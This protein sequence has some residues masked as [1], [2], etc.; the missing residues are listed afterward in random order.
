MGLLKFN[1]AGWNNVSS[2]LSGLSSTERDR[3]DMTALL[4]RMIARGAR[5][6]AVPIEGRWGEVDNASDLALYRHDLEHGLI[7]APSIAQ[8]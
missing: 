6:A 5:V 2:L 8:H 7:V 3:L 4:Q 1:P